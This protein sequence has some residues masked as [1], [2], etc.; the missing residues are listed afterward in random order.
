MSSRKEK[1]VQAY[2]AQIVVTEEQIIVGT[3]ITQDANDMNQMVPMLEATKDALAQAG[4]DGVPREVLADTGYWNEASLALDRPGEQDLFIAPFRKARG[5]K[6]KDGSEPEQKTP[7]LFEEK[8]KTEES[9]A[10]LKRRGAIVEAVFGQIK[11]V[12]GATRFMRRGIT[13]CA[14]EW[15]LLCTTH[16]LLKLFRARIKAK[17]GAAPC[18]APASCPA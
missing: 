1:Y 18:L 3:E 9:K 17:Q 16:N 6:R 12:R 8:M 4:I 2:N 7:S 13:A 15:K 5:R 14:S 10:V 11:T